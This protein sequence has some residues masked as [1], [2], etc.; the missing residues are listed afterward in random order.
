MQRLREDLFQ[1]LIMWRNVFLF[2]II[3]V[4]TTVGGRRIC[5]LTNIETEDVVRQ[6]VAYLVP[7]C[8]LRRSGGCKV[9]LQRTKDVLINVVVPVRGTV[10]LEIIVDVVVRVAVD[11]GGRVGCSWE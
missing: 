2:C 3:I 6:V 10:E 7:F 1:L 9:L 5:V 11:H 8:G 4:G